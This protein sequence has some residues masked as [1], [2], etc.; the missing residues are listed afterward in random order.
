MVKQGFTVVHHRVALVVYTRL[1]YLSVGVA[2]VSFEDRVFRINDDS[3]LFL[4]QDEAHESYHDAW[5]KI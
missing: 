1:R 3:T 2:R 5:E 4:F